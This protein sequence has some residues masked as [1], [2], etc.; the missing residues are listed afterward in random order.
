MLSGY[1]FPEQISNSKGKLHTHTKGKREVRPSD[2]GNKD[3]VITNG[4]DER[5]KSKTKKKR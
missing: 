3:V 1:W 4:K 2:V 5:H